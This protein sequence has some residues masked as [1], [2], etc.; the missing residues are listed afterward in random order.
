MQALGP[1]FNQLQTEMTQ[2]IQQLNAAIQ[3][4]NA[5]ETEDLLLAALD[6]AAGLSVGWIPFVGGD[7]EKAAFFAAKQELA[8]AAVGVIFV[9]LYPALAVVIICVGLCAKNLFQRLQR[10]LWTRQKFRQLRKSRSCWLSSTVQLFRLK[11]STHKSH[12]KTPHCP[13]F[14]QVLTHF[15][16][17]CEEYFRHTSELFCRIP[18]SLRVCFHR[19]ILRRGRPGGRAV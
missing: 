7:A 9:C 11:A 16:D 3:Q 6:V 5:E 2:K 19:D 1:L 8:A 4:A 18:F 14:F 13:N 17:Y 12:R 10:S 15:S